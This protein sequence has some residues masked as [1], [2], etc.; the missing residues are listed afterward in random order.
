MLLNYEKLVSLEQD[1]IYQITKDAYAD[2]R[3]SFG[4]NSILTHYTA[5]ENLPKILRKN[6]I[7]LRFSA[8]EGM[9]DSKEGK[10]TESIYKSVCEEL[11]KKAKINQQF[12]KLA[13]EIEADGKTKADGKTLFLEPDPD[14]KPHCLGLVTQL[15]RAV[16]LCC[17]SRKPNSDYMWQTYIKNEKREG[18]SLGFRKI[19][20]DQAAIVYT[21]DD[22]KTMLNRSQNAEFQ[23]I[24]VVYKDALKKSYMETLI[25][26][27]YDYWKRGGISDQEV[28]VTIGEILNT[29]QYVFKE[30]QY[31][32]EEEVRVLLYIPEKQ[33]YQG[34]DGQKIRHFE[35]MLGCCSDSEVKWPTIEKFELTPERSARSKSALLQ[36]IRSPTLAEKK[37]SEEDIEELK[38]RGYRFQEV[39]AKE[40]RA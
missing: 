34:T 15:E 2:E 16:Y 35:V 26:T 7:V 20:L 37:N 1:L 29:L 10:V 38:G 14:K 31:A 39:N 17:F 22:G 21:A 6:G 11:L 18:Y 30:P 25:L 28:G 27:V 13:I 40:E 5:S 8:V 3:E 23:V 12:C 9:N 32:D 33:K 19:A 36:I 4:S 24:P